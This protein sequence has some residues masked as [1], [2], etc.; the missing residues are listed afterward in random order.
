MSKDSKNRGSR[1]VRKNFY[2]PE[3]Y[4]KEIEAEALRLDRS[5]SWIIQR[6]WLEGREKIKKYPSIDDADS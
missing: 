4:V 3:S 6:A 5:L 1:S 2:L